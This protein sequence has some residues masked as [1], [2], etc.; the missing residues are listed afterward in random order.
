M[1]GC[2][3]APGTVT[4][5]A[6]VIV[7][8]IVAW[9]EKPGGEGGSVFRIGMARGCWVREREPGGGARIDNVWVPDESRRP[10]EKKAWW[11]MGQVLFIMYIVAEEQSV[12]DGIEA[13]D[14]GNRE[15][16]CLGSQSDGE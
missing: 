5:L 11:Y 7:I 3:Y 4:I 16:D 14:V 10:E 8:V 9:E 1:Q 12:G 6:I 2:M 15:A 13:D